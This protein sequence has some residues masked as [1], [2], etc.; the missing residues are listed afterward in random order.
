M[1]E[2]TGWVLASVKG[3]PFKYLK[4]GD[5]LSNSVQSFSAAEIF[6][7]SLN[8]QPYK[9]VAI[10]Q[11]V[12]ASALA[13]ISYSTGFGILDDAQTLMF[14]HMIKYLMRL[15]LS[16]K[17]TI[18]PDILVA[19]MT[20][21]QSGSADKVATALQNIEAMVNNG[22]NMLDFRNVDPSAMVNIIFTA[23]LNQ[24]KVVPGLESYTDLRLLEQPDFK[25]KLTKLAEDLKDGKS[26]I[27]NII[28]IPEELTEGNS[29]R[30]EAMSRSSRFLTLISSK[31]TSISTPVKELALN[32]YR[33]LTND[34]TASNLEAVGV[35]LDANNVISNQNFN[36]QN[37]V[38]L[39]KLRSFEEMLTTLTN[40]SKTG[41]IDI[42][43]LVPWYKEQI[44]SLDP[45]L[46][47]VLEDD[48]I[49][50]GLTN[51]IKQESEDMQTQEQ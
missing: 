17:D 37:E 35:A 28:G 10:N 6:N 2:P 8:R 23:V 48:K 16:V 46:P 22:E 32:R 12:G 49:I 27:A 1:M 38:L 5:M 24:I 34:K 7:I 21:K 51:M 42:G 9:K 39:A 18:R 43:K 4:D 14:E 40:I 25:E 44:G 33:V 50:S 3:K 47:A 31:L 13:D 41:L 29:N 20:S 36:A 26:S 45:T 19:T 30:W 11:N 15:L